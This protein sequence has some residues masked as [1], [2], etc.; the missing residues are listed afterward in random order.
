MGEL[1]CGQLTSSGITGIDEVDCAFLQKLG[2]VVGGK[3]REGMEHVGTGAS[4]NLSY[5]NSYSYSCVFCLVTVP[6]TP[7]FQVH[8]C[9][10]KALTELIDLF[11]CLALLLVE[12]GNSLF[13]SD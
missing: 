6:A 13:R 3:R 11:Q 10:E 2:R 1:T 7:V 8:C 12:V 5:P 4:C 9:E